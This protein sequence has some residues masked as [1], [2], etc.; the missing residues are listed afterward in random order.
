[1][2]FYFI[3]LLLSNTFL[4]VDAQF[5]NPYIQAEGGIALNRKN[6]GVFRTEIGT[7]YK[8]LDI[9]LVLDR[10]SNS[11]FKEYNAEMNVF[12]DVGYDSN[13]NHNNEFDYFTNTSLQLIA[14]IDIIRLF[15]DK[16]R[17]GLKFGGG[18]GLV[19]YQKAWSYYGFNENSDTEYA[20][21]ITSNFGLLGSFKLEYQYE[22]LPK[23]NIGTSFGGTFYPALSIL[24]RKDL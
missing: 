10:E 19:R 24:L 21:A 4:F 23:L 22:I 16:T 9:G 3:L 18:F 20:L 5:I 13:R 17:H 1:M 8:W 11:F 12:K 7:T 15:I 14:K 6:T 2:K